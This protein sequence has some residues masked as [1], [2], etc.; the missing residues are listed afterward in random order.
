MGKRGKFEEWSVHIVMVH[1]YMSHLATYLYG[2]PCSALSV[3]FISPEDILYIHTHLTTI[4]YTAYTSELLLRVCVRVCDIMCACDRVQKPVLS[5]I[6]DNG[7]PSENS[8]AFV[9]L[10]RD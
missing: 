1:D 8:G 6:I 9:W 10:R 2:R 4:I 7:Q 3:R 5:I